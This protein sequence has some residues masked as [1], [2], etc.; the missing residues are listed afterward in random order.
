MTTSKKKIGHSLVF[1]L[2]NLRESV[3]F[4]INKKTEG[5]KQPQ[6]AED[7]YDRLVNLND[8]TYF[9]DYGSVNKSRIVSGN[10]KILY[11]VLIKTIFKLLT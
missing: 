6:W 1:L 7:N 8:Y 10:L 5:L 9:V 4:V 2:F 3:V 11:L